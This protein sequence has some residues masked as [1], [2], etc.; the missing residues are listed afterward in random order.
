MEH[1]DVW[2][3]FLKFEMVHFDIITLR[4]LVKL[5]AIGM[6]RGD[7][8]ITMPHMH[9]LCT[10]CLFELGRMY[11]KFMSSTICRVSF[12]WFGLGFVVLV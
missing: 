2:Y 5:C 1:C 11:N 6:D 10:C 8:N 12:R 3:K 7:A 4:N 9:A